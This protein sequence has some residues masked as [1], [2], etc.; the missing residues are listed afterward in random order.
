MKQRKWT[1]EE[2]LPIVL[3]GLKEKR[4]VADVWRE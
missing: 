4:L 3:E 1:E 2:K